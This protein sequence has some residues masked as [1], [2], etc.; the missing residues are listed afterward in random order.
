MSARGYAIHSVCPKLPFSFFILV[1]PSPVV[2]VVLPIWPGRQW[3]RNMKE[4]WTQAAHRPCP[5]LSQSAVQYSSMADCPNP[6]NERKLHKNIYWAKVVKY[7]W[8]FPENFG[9]LGVTH[10]S[11]CCA[12]ASVYERNKNKWEGS[13]QCDV[14]LCDNSVLYSNFI[15]NTFHNFTFYGTSESL[16]PKFIVWDD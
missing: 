10:L 11:E 12:Y 2:R 5:S 16:Y 15:K 14:R 6:E 1:K 3:C 7:I 13:Q 8:I 4:T 9:F